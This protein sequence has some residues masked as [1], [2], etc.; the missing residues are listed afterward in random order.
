MDL[1]DLENLGQQLRDAVDAFDFENLKREIRKNADDVISGAKGSFGGNGPQDGPEREHDFRRKRNR[2]GAFGTYHRENWQTYRNI[3]PR[4]PGSFWGA[5]DPD[6][7]APGQ[8]KVRRTEPSQGRGP[9]GGRTVTADYG[10]PVERCPKGELSGM[11]LTVF[12]ALGFGLTG[13]GAIIL[14]GWLLVHPWRMVGA[15]LAGTVFFVLVFTVMMAVGTHQRNRVKRFRRYIASMK[16]KSFA[17][18]KDLASLTGRSVRYTIRDLAKMLELGYFPQGHMDSHRTCIMVTDEIYRQ[19][20]ETMKHAPNLNEAEKQARKY[21]RSGAEDG[22]DS[23]KIAE[24]EALG[25]Q[26]M[27]VIRQA[28]DD[29]PDVAFSNKLYRMEAVIGKIFEHVKEY[30]QKADRLSQFQNYYMPMTIKLVQTYRDFDTESIEGENIRKVR[31]E[32]E[33]TLDTIN[34]AYE[35]LYDSMYQETAMDVSSDISVLK[36]LLAR[37]GL[38]RGAFEKDSKKTGG[39]KV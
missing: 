14:A 23:D 10:F 13:I 9:S 25:R 31:Q 39:N 19:Y 15:A 5:P 2:F 11:L 8:D 27:D 12:G 4:R 30:P 7:E 34:D 26:Y 21:S 18:F 29:I 6:R 38:T 36:T 33:E 37:E 1:R 28:N 22:P 20:L 24:L 3:R 17:T 16:G 32:I 35:R